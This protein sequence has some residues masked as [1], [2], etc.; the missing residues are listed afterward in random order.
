MN[1]RRNPMNRWLIAVWVILFL[2]LAGWTAWW[3]TLRTQAIGGVDQWIAKQRAAGANVSYEKVEA[4]GFPFR[5]SLTFDNV[6]YAAPG[7][8][9]VMAT[10]KVQLH[11]NPSDLSLVI[12]EPR[13][14]VSW[15]TRGAAR[16]FTPQESAISVHI[17]NLAVDRVVVEG[18]GVAITKDGKP[19]FIVGQFVGG[20]RPDPRAAGDGQLSVDAQNVDLAAP[21]KGVEGMGA[22]IQTLSARI[23]F[24]KGAVLIGPGEDRVGSWKQ[25]GGA[26]RV[27][28]LGFTWGPATISSQGKFALDDQRRLAGALDINLEKPGE[29]F[30]ALAQSPATEPGMAKMY[31]MM[32]AAN[33]A[34]GGPLKAPLVIENGVML[35]NNLPITTVEPIK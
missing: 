2:A 16:T 13:D 21:P 24:E 18:K 3:F 35:F 11:I 10:P 33:T 25:A 14:T 27:E 20:L 31:A 12:V 15:T 5:L 22:K 9:W 29:T 6:H 30:G 7:D 8:A 17:T 19:D 1:A 4:S 34:R 32:G 23:V 26:A 28:G